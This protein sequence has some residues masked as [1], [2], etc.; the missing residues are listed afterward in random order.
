LKLEPRRG[1]MLQ[2]IPSQFLRTSL[3]SRSLR[4]P[5]RK[6]TPPLLP[7]RALGG[8]DLLAPLPPRML[9][10][11]RTVCGCQRVAFMISASVAPLVRFIIAITS[12]SLLA[13]SALGLLAGFLA[14]PTF[15]AGFLLAVRL[16]FAFW[17][18]VSGVFAAS[19]VF[20][21][22]VFLLDR[23]AVV[24]DHSNSEKLQVESAA[25]RRIGD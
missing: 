14:R 5:P 2:T 23:V 20:V 15:F 13:R 16:P 25:I 3:D 6:A 22:V 18:F 8:F 4:T 17:A 24:I 19:I 7:V 10:K 9:T 1:V 12:P 11:P 21:L